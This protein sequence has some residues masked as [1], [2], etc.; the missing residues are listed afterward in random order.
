MGALPGAGDGG[1]GDV[2]LEA[3]AP[4]TATGMALDF[5]VS[6][7]AEV[8]GESM[9]AAKEAPVQKQVAALSGAD[10]SPG[11]VALARA[12]APDRFRQNGL[13]HIGGDADRQL[14]ALADQLAEGQVAP[15]QIGTRMASSL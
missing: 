13:P 12:S 6:G 8:A 9:R 4:A 7:M 10:G 2:S 5:I 1:P 3:A 11:E 15:A 14:K